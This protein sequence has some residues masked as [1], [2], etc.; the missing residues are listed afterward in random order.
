[1]DR[2]HSGSRGASDSGRRGADRPPGRLGRGPGAKTW[3]G[4]NERTAR[5]PGFPPTTSTHSSPVRTLRTCAMNDHDADR[6]RAPE[7]STGSPVRTPDH[8]PERSR[9]GG[10]DAGGVGSGIDTD[11][12][13]PA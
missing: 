7:I 10:D 4:R 1:M 6:A 8:A 5:L 3:S 11:D 9:C 13:T 2:V 12:G